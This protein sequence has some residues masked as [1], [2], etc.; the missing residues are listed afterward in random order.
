MSVERLRGTLLD[1]AEAEARAVLAEADRRAA[2]EV[3]LAR[4]DSERLQDDA[5]AE[6]E[7]AGELQSARAFALKRAAARRLVLEA[8]EAVYQD[9][10]S[11]SL[12]AALALRDDRETYE[13]LLARLAAEARRTLGDDAELEL[14]PAGMGGVR[15]R[16]GKRSV[17]LTLPILVDR[18]IAE[19]GVGVEELWR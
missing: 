4:T 10:R 8:R 7:A 3:E 19:L 18:C 2:A 15:A 13:R 17:D 11:R 5:R 1:G 12:A 16:A 6:G 14:D 9:F